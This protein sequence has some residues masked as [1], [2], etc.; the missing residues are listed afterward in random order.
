MNIKKQSYD[1]GKLFSMIYINNN[2]ESHR[3]DGPAESRYYQNG[4]IK[5][6]E[7]LLK[8]NYHRKNGPARILYYINKQVQYESYLLNNKLHRMDGPSRIWYY[9]NGT[10]EKQEYY[11]NGIFYNDIFK[12]MVAIG[13]L[14]R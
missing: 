7:Y 14:E 11:L 1:N 4:N 8:D 12:W 9:E 6:E 2:G 5:E 10:I 3:I 13:N